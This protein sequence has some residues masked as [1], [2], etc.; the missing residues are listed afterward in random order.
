MKMKRVVGIALAAG[1]L[2]M[3]AVSAWAAKP[4]CNGSNCADQ[5]A[6]EKFSREA[7]ETT[8]AL[9]AKELEL[10]EQYGYDGIDANRVAE[11]Q[12]EIKGLRSSLQVVAERHGILPCCVR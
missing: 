9:K 10:R 11:L 2:S 8:G 1:I 3:G 12:A 6:V 7:A 5:Q 4:C